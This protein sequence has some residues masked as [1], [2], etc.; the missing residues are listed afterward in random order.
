MKQPHKLQNKGTKNKLKKR[1][2][3]WG[4]EEHR[5][6]QNMGLALLFV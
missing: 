3:F 1:S 6:E 2:Q 5:Q 4:E